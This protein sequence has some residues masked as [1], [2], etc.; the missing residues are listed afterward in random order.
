M[1][2]HIACPGFY[3]GFPVLWVLPYLFISDFIRIS[4]FMIII[5]YLFIPALT[6]LPPEYFLLDT[7]CSYILCLYSNP[8]FL[9]LISFVVFILVLLLA[10]LYMD[11]CVLGCTPGH[12]PRYMGQTSNNNNRFQL[13]I[14]VTLT[15]HVMISDMY[16]RLTVIWFATLI[17][18]AW[19]F[20]GMR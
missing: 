5:P 15:M 10:S 1:P 14:L 2:Y 12:I 8:C 13:L 4:R 7:N 3:F 9:N 19:I 11:V 18:Y 6:Y 17:L 20:G 16:S